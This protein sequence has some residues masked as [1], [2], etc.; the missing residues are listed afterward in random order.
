MPPISRAS[1]PIPLRPDRN[2]IAEATISTLVRTLIATARH[3]LD[4]TV[5]PAEVA[6]RSWGDEAPQVEYLLRAASSPAQIS[7]PSWAGELAHVV[8]IFLPSLAPLSAGVQLLARG[9]QLQFDNA[10]VIKLPLIPQGQASFVGELKP[11]PV[12]QFATSAGVTLTPF[13]LATITVLTRE[14]MDSSNAEQIVRQTLSESVSNGLDAAMFSVGPGSASQP[15]G[16]LYGV[17]ASTKSVATD[18]NLA[19]I[20]DL[21]TIA[22]A[23]ARVAGAGPIIFVAAPEQAASI[24]LRFPKDIDYPVLATAALSAGTVI[25]VAANALVSAFAGTPQIE[26]N[27]E[28][29][30]VMDSVPGEVASAGGLVG[31]PIGS[32]FQTDR[33]ALK[34]SMQTNWCL[35]TAGAVSWVS[36]TTW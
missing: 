33:V 9:L 25:A 18:K 36:G 4:R 35:R 2:A 34:I 27:R 20:D 28:A 24:E 19:M 6:K 30:L 8:T 31:A 26:A 21:S 16:L 3:Q 7:A 32:I 23:V 12:N 22:G 5:A 29:E 15:Q 10:A 11:I 14:I 17:G 1:R 13:K